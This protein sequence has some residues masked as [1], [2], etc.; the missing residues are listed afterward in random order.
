TTPVGTYTGS[1]FSAILTSDANFT[2]VVTDANS[3]TASST[4]HIDAID[5]RCFA[6]NSGN[7]KVQVCHHTGS[8]TNPYVQ[9][10]VSENAVPELIALGDCIGP[11]SA[12]SNPMNCSG[13]RMVSLDENS[14]NAFK[15]FPNPFNDKTTVSFSVPTEGN[16]VVR[17]FDAQGKEV[18]E[19][20]N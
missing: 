18:I 6:G 19:L 2:V 10:C 20:F 9:I 7:V 8:A 15:V 14:S 5:S 16:T 3:C 12:Y 4:V 11:C 17:I 1:S 13:Y